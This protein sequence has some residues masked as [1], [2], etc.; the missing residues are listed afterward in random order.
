MVLAQTEQIETAAKERAYPE[1][2]TYREEHKKTKNDTFQRQIYKILQKGL[3][4]VRKKLICPRKWHTFS[5][6][7]YLSQENGF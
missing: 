2:S 7:L 4:N 5:P 3:N 6:I 1:T